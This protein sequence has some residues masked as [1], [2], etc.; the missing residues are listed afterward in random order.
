MILKKEFHLCVITNRGFLI[1]IGGTL[2]D[3][4]NLIDL[5]DISTFIVKLISERS[6][7]E[8]ELIDCIYDEYDVDIET[9][10]RDLHDIFFK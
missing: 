3:V 10:R 2:V 9:I 8:E 6:Y 5:N 1:P 4:N 7:S